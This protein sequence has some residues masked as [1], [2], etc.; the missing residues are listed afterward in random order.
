MN[1]PEAKLKEQQYTQKVM[2]AVIRV[3]IVLLL[4]LWSFQIFK[5]FLGPVV[6]GIIIAIACYQIYAWLKQRRAAAKVEWLVPP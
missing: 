3:G 4:A 6:W 2:E 1:V 5:P